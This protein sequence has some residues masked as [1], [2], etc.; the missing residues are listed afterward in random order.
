MR[1][2]STNFI[3]LLAPFNIIVII[4]L[5]NNCESNTNLPQAIGD[6]LE[7]IVV[8][9]QNLYEESFYDNL[10]FILKRDIGPSPQPENTLSIIEVNADKFSGIL[11]RH[12]NILLISKADSFSIGYKTNMFA[13][14]Q[15]VLFLNCSSSQDLNANTQKLKSLIDKIKLTEIERMI[16]A[17]QKNPSSNLNKQISTKHNLDFIFPSGFFYAYEDSNTTWIRR[18]T[19]SISQG[20]FFTNFSKDINLDNINELRNKIN[21]KISNHILGPI[22]G[23]F[24]SVDKSAPI[25]IDTF[26]FDKSEA[27]KIQSLWRMEND[28]MGGVFVAYFLAD[29][30][31][32]TLIYSYLYAPGEPKKIPLLQLE[33]LMASLNKSKTK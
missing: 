21:S 18:E 19:P 29:H 24:M 32:P 23:S 2:L 26:L 11:K 10:K 8:K 1:T 22:E 9:D 14:N 30:S 5:F 25:T 3:Y 33:A 13:N 17:H 31:P 28:F 20:I 16:L 15:L 7:L 6:P 27:I 12:Q 4:L